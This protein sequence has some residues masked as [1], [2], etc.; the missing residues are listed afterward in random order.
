MRHART[1]KHTR[2]S[3]HTHTQTHMFDQTYLSIICALPSVPEVDE[4]MGAGVGAFVL[5]Q[6]SF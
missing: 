6:A 4:E 2:K 5:C 3:T 1:R